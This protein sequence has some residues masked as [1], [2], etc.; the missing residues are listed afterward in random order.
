MRIAQ[1]GLQQSVFEMAQAL[2]VASMAA[3]WNEVTFLLPG[4]RQGT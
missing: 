3:R 4:I 2:P 1:H